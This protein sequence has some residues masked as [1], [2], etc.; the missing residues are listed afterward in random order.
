[1]TSLEGAQARVL[2]TTPLEKTRIHLRLGPFLDAVTV[3]LAVVW[4]SPFMH[5]TGVE[6]DDC[7]LES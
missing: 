2:A 6:L 5:K 7:K 4:C 3:L 1:M